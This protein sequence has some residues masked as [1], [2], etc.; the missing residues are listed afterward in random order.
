MLTALV[1]AAAVREPRSTVSL[2]RVSPRKTSSSPSPWKF[3]RTTPEDYSLLETTT[4]SGGSHTAAAG[5]PPPEYPA[6]ETYRQVYL[7]GAAYCDKGLD[8][9]TCLYCNGGGEAC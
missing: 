6:V 1:A 9:W 8:E 2:G 5:A 7:A 4:A 3:R